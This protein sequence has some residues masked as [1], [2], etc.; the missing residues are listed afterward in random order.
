MAS[1]PWCVLALMLAACAG[2]ARPAQAAPE[3]GLGE[4]NDALIMARVVEGGFTV[5]ESAE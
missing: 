1:R 4:N 2:V 3:I 5:A